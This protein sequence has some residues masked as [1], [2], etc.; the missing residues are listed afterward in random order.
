MKLWE[1]LE[2]LKINTY[3]ATRE[4]EIMGEKPK[5]RQNAENKQTSDNLIRWEK[6]KNAWRIG[7]S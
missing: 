3:N 4:I 6:L 5:T 7:T 2:R 1:K